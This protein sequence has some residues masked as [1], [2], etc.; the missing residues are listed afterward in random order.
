[1]DGDVGPSTGCSFNAVWMYEAEAPKVVQSLKWDALNGLFQRFDAPPGIY[2]INAIIAEKDGPWGPGGEAYFLE[3]TPRMG[4]DSETT[5]QRLLDG[6]GLGEFFQRLVTGRLAEAPFRTDVMAYATRLSVSPYPWEHNE[7][8]KKTCE[9]TP[10]YGVD[11]LWE[12]HFIGYSVALGEDGFY[13]ADR[14]GLVGLSLALGTSVKKAHDECMA[15]VKDTLEV[16]SLQYRRDG[17]T[18]VEKDAKALEKLGF[19]V[20]RGLLR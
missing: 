15:Y 5:S 2:D 16:P 17:A 14:T 12:N 3:W 18:C 13:V 7:D 8:A 6:M 10:I 20:H 1:M 4:F 11:G 19:E 9:G